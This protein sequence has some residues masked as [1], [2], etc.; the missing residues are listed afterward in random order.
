MPPVRRGEGDK[1]NTHTHTGYTHRIPVSVTQLLAT[2][3]GLK[4]IGPKLCVIV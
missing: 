3:I 1:R 2:Q 4:Y